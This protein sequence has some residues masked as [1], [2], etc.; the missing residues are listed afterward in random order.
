MGIQ[1]IFRRRLTLSTRFSLLIAGATIAFGLSGACLQQRSLYREKQ[2]ATRHAVEVA[3]GVMAYYGQLAESGAMSDADARKAAAAAIKSLRYEKTD[4][5]WINDVH[6]RVVMHPI[7]EKLVGQDVSTFADPNGKLI[8]VEAVKM[9]S[10]D[11]GGHFE[12]MWPKPGETEPKPKL[13]YVKL[14]PRWNWVIGS[15]IH[16]EDVRRELWSLI[17][18]FLSV[19]ILVMAIALWLASSAMRTVRHT[20]TALSAGAE[21]VMA[22]AEQVAA[23]AQSLSQG[24]SEQAASLEETSAST[25]ELAATTRQNAER[26]RQSAELVRGVDRSVGQAN[27][28]L[29]SMAG[30]MSAIHESSA[31]VSKIVKTIDEI[32]FQTNI[33]ALNAAVEAAR[34]GEAGMGFAVVA[35]EVR[36]LAQRAATAARDTTALIERASTSARDGVVKLDRMSAT[37]G[38]IT[39]SVTSLSALV[40]EVSEATRQQANGLEQVRQSVVQMEHVTQTTAATAEQSAAA[41]QE[42]NALAAGATRM[43]QELEALIG[44]GRRAA[45]TGHRLAPSY[46]PAV[47]PQI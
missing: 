39:T 24:A 37:V 12:Y 6:P 10:R 18:A 21:Q 33:L 25:E 36:N 42:L 5:F 34:A 35:D 22:A 1:H 4:Y 23:A 16:I 7:N 46:R 27:D 2:A 30:S 17:G 29:I 47:V 8:Y 44:G 15:G 26:S 38:Q 20:T 28:A 9:A 40:G 19:A 41:S 11:G 31:Q 14:Y 43:V 45:A 32:A 13:S 3:Y